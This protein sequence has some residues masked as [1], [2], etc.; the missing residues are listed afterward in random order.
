[1]LYSTESGVKR[2][3]VVLSVKN[4]MRLFICVHVGISYSYDW[5]L[6]CI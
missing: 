4:E 3:H 5:I 6:Q 1:M 2:G